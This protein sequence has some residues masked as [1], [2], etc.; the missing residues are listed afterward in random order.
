MTIRPPI[1]RPECAKKALRRGPRTPQESV[2]ESAQ[3]RRSGDSDKRPKA[4]KADGMDIKDAQ[5][6]HDLV[7]QGD[8]GAT[9]A[10]GP[11]VVH[12]G[13]RLRSQRKQKLKV[14]VLGIVAKWEGK[15]VLM[16]SPMEGHITVIMM[17]LYYIKERGN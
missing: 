3:R 5:I 8:G 12:L 9:D 7:P 17:P 15:I 14:S 11:Q 2:P 13:Q 6:K 1:Q 16:S 10:P 4:G